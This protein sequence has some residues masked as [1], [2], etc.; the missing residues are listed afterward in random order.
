M[1]ERELP[2]EERDPFRGDGSL[3][4]IVVENCDLGCWRTALAY[5]ASHGTD[6]SFTVNGNSEPLPTDVERVFQYWPDSSPLLYFRVAGIGLACHFF[7]EDEIELDL[8]PNSV[9]TDAQIAGVRAFLQGLAD[10][11]GREVLLTSENQH[12]EVYWRVAPSR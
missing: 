3:R 7:S 2:Y 10:A 4:D 1:S 8:V 11:L 5:F 6:P 9:E 12:S